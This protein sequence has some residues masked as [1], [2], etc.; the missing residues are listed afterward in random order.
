MREFLDDG[1]DELAVLAHAGTGARVSAIIS[2]S[3]MSLLMLPWWQCALW[4][5]F[6][7]AYEAD[8]WFAT[9]R[10]YQGLP[11]SK[12]TRVHHLAGLAVATGTWVLLGSCSGGPARRRASSAP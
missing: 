5:G 1:L 2:T 11:V 7:L 6:S 8:S 9:R 3:L 10:Q 12:L 4:C